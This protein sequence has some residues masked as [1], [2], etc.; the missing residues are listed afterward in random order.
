METI[1]YKREVFKIV[2]ICMEVHN[3]L[4]HGF[5]EIVYKDAMEIE[6]LS[7]QIIFTREKE[8]NIVYKGHILKRTFNADFFTMDKIIVE[9]KS[10]KEG[11]TNGN[12]AQSINYLKVSGCQLALLVNFGRNSLEYKRL[13][14]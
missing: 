14:F 12:V 13:V 7:N 1:L 8:F 6:F 5:L 10:S 3:Y 11:L 4:G 9:V 2:G